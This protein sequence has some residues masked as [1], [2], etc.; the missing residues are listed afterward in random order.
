MINES[1]PEVQ[2]DPG[3]PPPEVP[4]SFAAEQL[5]ASL[6]GGGAVHG[7]D[8]I[9]V[10]LLEHDRSVAADALP[11]A[12]LTAFEA[13]ARERLARGERTDR[14]GRDD[15]ACAAAR[16][17]SKHG[18]D[19][20]TAADV[21]VAVLHA[22]RGIALVPPPPPAE[23][24]VADAEETALPG[25][26]EPAPSEAARLLDPAKDRI[27]ISYSHR[28]NG[29]LWKAELLEAL[30]VFDQHGLLDVWQDG[31]IRVG[32]FWED[33]IAQAMSSAR[34]A[35]VLLT[36]EALE[37]QFIRERELPFLRERQQHG[38]LRVF[39]VVCEPCGWRDIDWLRATQ[40]PTGGDPLAGLSKLE[41]DELLRQLAAQVAEEIGRAVLSELPHASQP[42]QADHI[43]LDRFP[44]TRGGGELE[45]LIGR[46]QELALLDLAFAQPSTAIVSLVAWGGVGKTMLVKHWLQHLQRE[47]WFSAQRV[48]GWSFHS[49]GTTED[50]HASEDAFLAHALEW[51]GVKCDPT[52]PPWDK[53]RLLADAVAG[54]RA[55][56]VLDGIEPLQYPPGPMGGQLRAPGL[57]TL[58][59]QLARRAKETDQHALCV[60]TTREPLA[61]LADFERRRDGAWGSALRVNLSN[62]TEIAGA[63]LLHHTG[64]S[65]AG[66]VGIEPDD[67]ELLRAS[68]EVDGHAL[69]LNLLGR[70]LARA[71]GGD[72]RRRDLVR[73]AEA[74]RDE[75]GGT[76]FRMLAA[77]E[78]WFAKGSE[79]GAHQLA[80]LRILGL[81]DRPADEPCLAAL[82]EP[83]AIAGLTDPLFAARPDAGST[84]TSVTPLADEDWNM[85]ISFLADFGLLTIQ[86]STDNRERLL[87]CHPLIREH[88]ARQLRGKN[89]ENW[90]SAHR[91]LYEYLR[92]SAEERP[93]SL[94]GLQ[95][96][97]HAVAHGCAAGLYE[98]T[99]R[100]VLDD[101]IRRGAEVYSVKQF[102]IFGTHLAAT[103]CFFER[104][105]TQLAS[106]ISEWSQAWLLNEAGYCLRGL[107]RL[108]ESVEPLQAGAELAA[109]VGD[110][111]EAANCVSIL[112]Q[113][114]LVL[115]RIP[116]AVTLAKQA[117]AVDTTDQR[118]AAANHTFLLD[119]Y[120]RPHRR[121]LGV[122][123]DALHQGGARSESTTCF[124]DAERIQ[125]ENE[126]GFPQLY[127]SIGFYF[128]ELLM[129]GL[130]RAAWQAQLRLPDRL[131]DL[132]EAERLEAEVVGRSS[133]S[134]LLVLHGSRNLLDIA[135]NQLALGRVALYADI[136]GRRRRAEDDVR[137]LRQA[138]SAGAKPECLP[139]VEKSLLADSRELLSSAEQGLRRAGT[140]HHIPRSVLSHAWLRVREGDL[141]GA[142]AGLD[143]AWDIAERGPMRLHMADIHLHRARLFFREERY[144]WRSPLD[145]LAAAEKLIDECGYHRRD[146]E[147]ADAKRAI[148]APR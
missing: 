81:F 74:D 56:L 138:I 27:F 118:R 124:R 42:T 15:L 40:A 46:D 103:S 32:A 25:S 70:F 100:D 86:V 78:N 94:E 68:R 98:E 39:P 14:I 13:A 71:H 69:T 83:P 63:A 133:A 10:R 66:R 125:A 143:E 44:L 7:L 55:L 117:I 102:G 91:R 109:H 3:Q 12:N 123:A 34:L 110:L 129:T 6:M 36:P 51:F 137:R 23:K 75:Q 18:R 49:Q 84:Q 93:G 16:N 5:L 73:F 121:D 37:S 80:I 64:A 76:T 26:R 43:Y 19:V 35:V 136:A 20:A 17:A 62:L 30:S 58:L 45:Q 131:V 111:W 79:T 112:S 145:D 1:P 59:R 96:L 24:G 139:L 65:M 57:Q 72:I 126:P 50:R 47:G 135:L 88:F 105:W 61:D 38:R 60:V 108:A 8:Q 4:L 9:V 122:L 22:A 141:E 2:R 92:D 54:E 142:R 82:R 52:L 113:V 97:Y 33:D 144:P 87:D 90:R 101:R 130:E 127:S 119:D 147:L 29:P 115:G 148:L 89:P 21:A 116:D 146:E 104:P 106:G 120:W 53:G 107:G 95:L 99:R 48:Y 128:T 77:F 132:G 28:G 41:L 134:L 85:A 140:A 114:F 67:T 31:R 11:G